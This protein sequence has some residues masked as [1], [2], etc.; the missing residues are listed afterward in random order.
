MHGCHAV[1]SETCNYF[2]VWHFIQYYYSWLVVVNV[3]SSTATSQD[4]VL[5]VCGLMLAVA[6]QWMTNGLVQVSH[7]Y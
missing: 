3:S 1:L 6:R 4:L 2:V 5:S 7:F